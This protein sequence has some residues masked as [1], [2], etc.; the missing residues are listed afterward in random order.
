MLDVLVFAQNEAGVDR[1]GRWVAIE[2]RGARGQDLVLHHGRDSAKV[3][4]VDVN[5]ELAR[6][7]LDPATPVERAEQMLLFEGEDATAFEWHKVAKDV[8]NS[9]NQ[10]PE[11]IAEVA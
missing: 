11:L 4:E 8:G 5:A 10:G 7:W 9:R 1:R 3:Q 2:Q 6:E